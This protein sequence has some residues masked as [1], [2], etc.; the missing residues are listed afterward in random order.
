M[1]KP[2]WVSEDTGKVYRT[3]VGYLFDELRKDIRT[4]SDT[5]MEQIGDTFIAT[6]L[7][8]GMWWEIVG[9][10]DCEPWRVGSYSK[11]WNYKPAPT[12]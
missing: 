5:R 4:Y 2:K 7:F 9:R 12:V 11:N 10:R 8:P 3:K 6:I 1:F